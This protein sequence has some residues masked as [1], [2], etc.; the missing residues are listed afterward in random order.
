MAD[1][2]FDNIEIQR[3]EKGA[4]QVGLSTYMIMFLQ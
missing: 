3:A 2:V 4:R 1:T